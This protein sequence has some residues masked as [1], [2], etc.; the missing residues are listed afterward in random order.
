MARRSIAVAAELKKRVLA[1]KSKLEAAERELRSALGEVPAGARAE[2]RM[3]S[4]TFRLVLKK[5]EAAKKKLA[6][7]GPALKR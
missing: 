2:K 5:V 3:I 4:E 6:A 7:I 1:A